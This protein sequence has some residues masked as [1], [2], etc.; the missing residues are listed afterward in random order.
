MELTTRE[1]IALAK[2]VGLRLAYEPD[3]EDELN[4]EF[5]LATGDVFANE[6]CTKYY[7]GNYVYL[8]E[9]P[10]EGYYPLSDKVYEVIPESRVAK[11]YKRLN[12]EWP[13]YSSQYTILVNHP[14]AGL[15]A[16]TEAMW[17]LNGSGC[18]FICTKKEFKDYGLSLLE[19]L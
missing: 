12:G 11:A 16:E 14:E 1:I 3:D 2:Y 19:D 4:C 9:Y 15:V 7:R 10:E 5:T 18:E 6:E 8:S 17:K 13:S